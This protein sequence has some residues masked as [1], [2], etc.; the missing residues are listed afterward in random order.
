MQRHCICLFIGSMD[1]KTLGI[2]RNF[3]PGQE[4]LVSLVKASAAQRYR[5]TAC[6]FTFCNPG[7]G[8]TIHQLY[9]NKGSKT[10]VI[11]KALQGRSNLVK[12]KTGNI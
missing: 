6:Y 4:L 2:S 9:L 5:F 3:V 8:T 7:L 10:I 12:F 1:C 11:F